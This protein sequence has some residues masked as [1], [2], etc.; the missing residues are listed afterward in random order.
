MLLLAADFAAVAPLICLL[1]YAFRNLLRP[2]P[3]V[4]PALRM[5]ISSQAAYLLLRC[6]EGVWPRLHE[7]NGEGNVSSMKSVGKILSRA[8]VED[9]LRGFC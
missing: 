2:L 6:G 7:I 3:H 4:L 1:H 8:S 9:A 5:G